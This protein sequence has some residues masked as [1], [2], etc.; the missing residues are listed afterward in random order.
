MLWKP[1]NLISL[2]YEIIIFVIELYF[3]FVK[4]IY[5]QNINSVF[6]FIYKIYKCCNIQFNNNIW[7]Y[8]L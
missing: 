5:F 2:I 8:Y 6:M 7:K 1:L 3:Y 4:I